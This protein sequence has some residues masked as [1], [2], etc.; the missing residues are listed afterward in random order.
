MDILYKLHKLYIDIM[1]Y[2]FG[3]K[4]S[5][6]T[7]NNHI[8]DLLD[9][10]YVPALDSYGKIIDVSINGSNTEYTCLLYTSPSPRD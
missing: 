6:L 2:L 1:I 4:R 5:E 7:M 8:F 10:V 9:I 3:L